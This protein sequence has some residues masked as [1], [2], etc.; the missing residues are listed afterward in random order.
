MNLKTVTTTATLST[1]AVNIVT[2]YKSLLTIAPYT[3]PTCDL[4]IALTVDEEEYASATLSSG[5]TEQLTFNTT[6]NTYAITATPTDTSNRCTL[7]N[8]DIIVQNRV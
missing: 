7:T 6:Y 5:S 1:T 4:T 2:N 8:A 3:A